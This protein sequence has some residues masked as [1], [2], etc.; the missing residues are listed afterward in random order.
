MDEPDQLLVGECAYPR[1]TMRFQ[2]FRPRSHVTA[3]AAESPGVEIRQMCVIDREPHPKLQAPR[4]AHFTPK[5]L[6]L[7]LLADDDTTLL[8]TTPLS[9]PRPQQSGPW[10]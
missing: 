1:E 7:R 9:A 6:E 8:A 3:A 5:I 10:L 2:P 4:N